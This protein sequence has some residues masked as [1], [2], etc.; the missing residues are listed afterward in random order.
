MA[1]IVSSVFSAHCQSHCDSQVGL[2]CLFLER[3][4]HMSSASQSL[5]PHHFPF[6]LLFN[7]WS[8][9]YYNNWSEKLSL[10]FLPSKWWI[11]LCF[12]PFFYIF[13]LI[14]PKVSRILF[15]V[16]C[17]NFSTWSLEF[18]LS[19]LFIDFTLSIS[20]SLTLFYLYFQCFRH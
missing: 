19:C 1:L 17:S 11:D 6:V 5:W 2:L 15:E 13:L 3:L 7:R 18:I 16:Y 4:I 20:L 14:I 10:K 8:C 9:P 12:H